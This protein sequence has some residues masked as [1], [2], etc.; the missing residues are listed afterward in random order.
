M[1]GPTDSYTVE[2]RNLS[3]FE[4][5]SSESPIATLSFFGN[6]VV[7]GS[8]EGTRRVREDATVFFL[9]KTRVGAYHQGSWVWKRSLVPAHGEIAS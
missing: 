7:G 9:E 8:R 4:R 6:P 1:G 3:L 5:R 2:T